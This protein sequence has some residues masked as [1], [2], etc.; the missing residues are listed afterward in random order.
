MT[1]NY[2]RMKKYFYCK[3]TFLWY[4]L[5]V[6]FFGWFVFPLLYM[7]FPSYFM[8]IS[9][10]SSLIIIA[11]AVL[12]GIYFGQRG[13]ASDFNE[14]VDELTFNFEKNAIQELELEDKMLVRVPP[15]FYKGYEYER[16]DIVY[17]KRGGDNHIRSNGYAAT[18][19]CAATDKFYVYRKYI[20]F[21]EDKHETIIKAYS[22]K[23]IGGL[24]FTPETKK[25]F[26]SGRKTVDLKYCVVTLTDANG[27]VIFSTCTNEDVNTIPTIEAINRQIE[28]A[29]S[30]TGK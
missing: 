19:V 5:A 23:E 28:E 6:I 21:I 30:K 26:K 22:Y 18:F 14:I 24:S 3:K 7:F 1:I 2:E 29:K 9:I 17:V 13:K 11:G 16:P 25:N 15:A 27:N 10:A 12:I 20:N 4:G 8:V